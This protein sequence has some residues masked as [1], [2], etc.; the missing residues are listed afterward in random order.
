MSP[1][2]QSAMPFND[3]RNLIENIP[4]IDSSIS[5]KHDL[6]AQ[7]ILGSPDDLGIFNYLSRFIALSQNRYPPLVTKPEIAI[8][9]SNQETE[10]N[11][12]PDVK[13][14]ISQSVDDISKGNHIINQIC[15]I[16]GCGLKTYDLNSE[17][18]TENITH[19][20]AMSEVEATQ[21]IA[22]SMEAVRDSDLLIISDVGL[23]HKIAPKAI[24]KAIWGDKI[25][26]EYKFHDATLQAISFHGTKHDPLE[27]LRRLG[28]RE[29]AA[30][31]GA[32]I[33]ARYQNVPIILD[34]LSALA[35]ASIIFAINTDG[36]SHCLVGHNHND[37]LHTMIADYLSLNPML[38]LNLNLDTGIG[39]AMLIHLIKN[40]IQVHNFSTIKERSS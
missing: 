24:L 19:E 6:H 30:M 21:I 15:N 1:L 8:F 17:L 39:S 23:G 31:I 26:S 40:A 36:I 10:N 9:V 25:P 29:I 33:A 22:Y 16:S 37:K 3:I 38:P 14:K 18:A 12:D 27:F 28:S 20:S 32:I 35:A 5:E 34:S 2:P 11:L 13:E 4:P 7:E